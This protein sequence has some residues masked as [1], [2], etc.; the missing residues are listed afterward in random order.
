MV[1]CHCNVVTD[2]E[3]RALADRGALTA[4]D[5]AERCA[6]GA[7]CGGCVPVIEALLTETAVAVRSAFVA[8]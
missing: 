7:R 4:D 8:A 6:A 2:R 3:I 5:V 1:V